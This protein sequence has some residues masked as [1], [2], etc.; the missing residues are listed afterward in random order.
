MFKI[1]FVLITVILILSGIY[2]CI[3]QPQFNKVSKQQILAKSAK[4]D[5]PLQFIVVWNGPIANELKVDLKIESLSG[6]A[7]NSLINNIP[8]KSFIF[9]PDF[10]NEYPVLLNFNKDADS[11]SVDIVRVSLV[12]RNNPAQEYD[13]FIV[14]YKVVLASEV[15]QPL[16]EMKKSVDDLRKL[17]LE[18][19]TSRA[20]LGEFVMKN[21]VIAIQPV[22]NSSRRRLIRKYKYDK[23]IDHKSIIKDLLIMRNGSQ[24]DIY[25]PKKQPG[26]SRQLVPAKY[27]LK[28]LKEVR[29]SISE[30]FIEYITAITND[31]TEFVYDTP[32]PVVAFDKYLQKKAVSREENEFVFIGDILELK[33]NNYYSYFPDDSLYVL[34]KE[35]ERNGK[36]KALSGLGSLIDFRLYTD[37][38]G[39]FGEQPNGLVQFEASSKIPLTALNVGRS[40][41][42]NFVQPFFKLSK[43]DSKYD[44]I[45]LFP[46]PN[47]RKIDK[48][49]LFQRS[50]L[51]L[52]VKAN[53]YK[54]NW[55][56]NN[57][58]SVNV[59]YL[60]SSGNVSIAKDTV[61]KGILHMPYTEVGF[62]TRKL[63]NFGFDADIRY[64]FQKLN[65][66]KYFDGSSWDDFMSISTTMFFYTAVKSQDKFFVRFTNYLNF[67]DRSDDFYQLQ[68]G[69]SLNL[70]LGKMK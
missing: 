18:G 7:K 16:H 45:T 12:D 34:K 2:S 42:L 29:L 47:G 50:F 61:T 68:F 43:L 22:G 33:T 20:N 70:S 58:V 1:Q 59:G 54:I 64:G 17:M 23:F 13:S 25:T 57:G 24:T 8:P 62:S 40:Y 46:S 44:T 32:I 11:S 55:R 49:E 10:S 69:Y 67:M 48:M 36:L 30:G 35:G 15:V 19:D 9:S 3:A 14:L 53:I 37:L 26:E 21:S 66:N 28:G 63:Q 51:N 39:T 31:S 5:V 4:Q 38:L 6:K 27:L 60:F 41:F 52:G 56:P 65:K